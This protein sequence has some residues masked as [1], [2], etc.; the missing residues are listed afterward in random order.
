MGVV[1]Q[2]VTQRERYLSTASGWSP[3]VQSNHA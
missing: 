1:A 2:G 3:A